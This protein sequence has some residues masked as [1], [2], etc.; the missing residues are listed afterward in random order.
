MKGV[1]YA[2]TQLWSGVDLHIK[3]HQ[4]SILD[5]RLIGLRT[6]RAEIDPR[7]SP[8][9]Q[10]FTVISR[11][12]RFV[13]N[14]LDKIALGADL[15][16][17]LTLLSCRITWVFHGVR[18]ALP[19]APCKSKDQRHGCGNR[20]RLFL[21]FPF[22]FRSSVTFSD[23]QE[24]MPSCHAINDSGNLIGVVAFESSSR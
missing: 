16:F 24:D 21:Q 15:R 10:F 22:S 6:L 2:S 23:Y 14:V 9:S 19:P 12:R 13:A 5:L 7:H 8:V 17:L 4:V 20:H 18:L 1:V 11:N 3:R